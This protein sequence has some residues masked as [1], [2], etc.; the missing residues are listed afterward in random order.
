MRRFRSGQTLERSESVIER[1]REINPFEDG[2]ALNALRS[3]PSFEEALSRLVYLAEHGRPWGMV[4]GPAGSGKT[5]LLQFVIREL[6]HNGQEC[7]VVDLRRTSADEFSWQVACEL[8]TAPPL[9]ERRRSWRLIEDAIQG[10][11]LAGRV[12]VMV[13]DHLGEQSSDMLPQLKRLL[14]IAETSAGWC[15]ILAAA[16]SERQNLDRFVQ[17]QSELRIE[18]GPLDLDETNEFFRRIVETTGCCPF[19]ADAVQALYE[20]SQGILKTLITLGRLTLIARSTAEAPHVTGQLVR[21]VSAEV[22]GQLFQHPRAD[23][24]ALMAAVE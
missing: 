18:L 9:A 12:T 7:G 8:G 22:P 4:C 10:R 16:R 24:P 13:L 1:C 5:Q 11:S 14:A 20:Y 3:L 21:S 23:Q 2:T 17:E 6:H 15:T 19:D